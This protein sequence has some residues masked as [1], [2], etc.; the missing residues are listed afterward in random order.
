MPLHL[1]HH[2]SYHPYNRE[3]IERV[4]RD[5]EAARLAAEAAEGRSLQADS[6]RRLELLRRNKG[7]ASGGSEQERRLRA[8][9][10]EVDGK[11]GALKEYDECQLEKL[12]GR[13]DADNLERT[14][15][16][17]GHINFWAHLED[18]N[19]PSKRACTQEPSNASLAS[20]QVSSSAENS[21]KADRAY[22][23]QPAPEMSPWYSSSDLIPGNERTKSKHQKLREAYKDSK[24]KKEHDPMNV[25]REAFS[26]TSASDATTLNRENDKRRAHLRHFNLPSGPNFSSGES[27]AAQSSSQRLK[28]KQQEAMSREA[29]E[30]ARAQALISQRRL[31]CEQS[32]ETPFSTPLAAHG[33][34]SSA[35]QYSDQFNRDD[36]RAAHA[37]SS[38]AVAETREEEERRWQREQEER[39]QDLKSRLLH[40]RRESQGQG[41]EARSGAS[42][43]TKSDAAIPTDAEQPTE[44]LF[45]LHFAG[46]STLLTLQQE[47]VGIGAAS[48]TSAGIERNPIAIDFDN[49][50]GAVTGR[51]HDVH[52]LSS[53]PIPVRTLSD[54]SSRT[55]SSTSCNRLA[56]PYSRESDPEVFQRYQES[57]YPTILGEMIQVVLSGEAH[58]FEEHEVSLLQAYHALSYQSRYMLARLLQRKDM[59]IRLNKLDY[60]SDVEDMGAAILELCELR[61]LPQPAP[62]GNASAIENDAAGKDT[63]AGATA[64]A[65]GEVALRF[66]IS[67]ADLDVD[68]EPI[69]NMLTLEELKTLAKSMQR[70]T[71]AAKTKQKIIETLLRTK[72]QGLL[73]FDGEAAEPITKKGGSMKPPA[74]KRHQTTLNF[75]PATKNA[76]GAPTSLPTKRNNQKAVLQVELANLIGRC[77]RLSP[78]ARKL[79]DRVALV[80]Y[81]GNV[82]QGAS[83]L[84]GAVL[85]R[86]QKRNY[87]VYEYARSPCL[88][89]TR[90]HLLAYE[91][92]LV[93]QAEMEQLL[94]WDGSK[95][96]LEKAYRLFESVWD[97]WKAV[98]VDCETL[99]EGV[100]RLTYHRMRLHAGWVL[101]RIIDKGIYCL[102]RFK[103]YEREKDVLRA[104][105]AQ[106]AF[107]RGKRG[108]W[109]DRLALILMQYS[110]DK[111]AGRK[112]A[113]EVCMRGLQ[114][115]DTHI[116]Y[117]DMLQ[118]R[119]KR[120]ESALRIPFAEQHDFSYAKLQ[121]CTE[122]TF[123]GVRL[124][125]ML[126]EK[127]RLDLFGRPI[128]RQMPPEKRPALRANSSSESLL[129]GD[130]IGKNFTLRKPLQKQVK[131]ERRVSA[132]SGTAAPPSLP[133]NVSP[134][135]DGSSA[136]LP[137]S[138]GDEYQTTRKETKESMATVW[139][140]LDGQPCRVEALCLQHYAMQG[141]KGYHSEGGV[142]VMLYVLLM[143]D[144]IYQP[145]EGAFETA[146]QN[147]PLDINTD[148]F[149]V[150]R[151][152]DIR[153][154]L[155]R[156]QN[157]GGLDL[158][159]ETDERERPRKTWAVGCR[160]DTYPLKDL[161][162]IAECLGGYS[163]SVICQ[164]FSEEWEHCSSGL[165]D[166]CIWRHR[167][168]LEEQESKGDELQEAALDAE[169]SSD[170]PVDFSASL[171]SATAPAVALPPLQTE[172]TRDRKR[173]PT[174][175]G[176]LRAFKPR[177]RFVEV[178]GPGD[179]L[180]ENQKLWIDLLL[181]A[182]VEVQ[183]AYV[184]EHEKAA[185]GGGGAGSAS[186]SGSEPSGN[187]KGKGK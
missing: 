151:G 127:Q 97:D 94:D 141:F 150:S 96:A 89:P 145:I 69:L 170:S 63:M 169:A 6:E 105:L 30:R 21:S 115:P 131:I 67:E 99:L 3:N 100:D 140:G 132:A 10:R 110:D 5:E 72:T 136:P 98:V 73:G 25:V 128:K 103:L 59:W 143:W 88:W 48:V 154:R 35:W 185:Q 29:A 109:Y 23:S 19:R 14:F 181:R 148:A 123:S 125:Q 114:D 31:E 130:G 122:V 53:Q 32:R 51:V 85:A 13:A 76:D 184:V 95:E 75:G 52:A 167:N 107:R 74:N 77:V 17:A 56:T 66:A 43:T 116:I 92:A 47:K 81:R 137:L 11:A 178:K 156:I 64:A 82:L 65:D 177:V 160:W 36:V 4:R 28:P 134:V 9:E 144:I 126:V 179:H 113:L 158:I 90:Q 34:S 187:S 129:V 104:L 142:L 24:R 18:N 57:M 50:D 83:V 124:D 147:A 91:A 149:A 86:S 2:K 119:I 20:K 93:L 120:L 164:V 117:H 133:R 111:T 58:L 162:E 175:G 157:D 183:V 174:A 172:S 55:S 138:A 40:G 15:D 165:P 118:R 26:F 121:Q 155:H 33:S 102:G 60:A 16:S 108:E 135:K 22:L 106:K 70:L 159:R 37:G 42:L 186:G 79:I 112:A 80:Y 168:H 8:A 62:T 180:R 54:E 161:L 173:R 176:A 101:T 49:E 45:D 166:L 68:M 146:Y 182:G 87:P 171:A 152:A 84:T 163:L 12:G 78:I 41:Q 44:E 71:P 153:Q 46:T 27:R 61:V 38:A 139:R 7:R 1:A 39:E